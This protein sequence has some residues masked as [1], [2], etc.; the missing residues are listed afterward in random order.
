FVKQ[1]QKEPKRPC[2][3]RTAFAALRFPRSG[4]APWARRHAEPPLGLPMGQVDQNQKPDQKQ[5]KSRSKADQKQIKSR[6]KA[7]QKQ[8]LWSPGFFALALE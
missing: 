3:W 4:P 6:S 2:P 7:D 1:P 8:V 5:I